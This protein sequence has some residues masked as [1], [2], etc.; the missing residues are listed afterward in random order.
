MNLIIIISICIFLSYLIKKNIKKLS[1]NNSLKS[2]TDSLVKFREFP[3]D[4][5]DLK[6]S[7]NKLSKT[8]SILILK[9]IIFSIPYFILFLIIN[10]I[11]IKSQIIFIIPL[12]PYFIVLLNDKL[13]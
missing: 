12:S 7:L 5:T 1:L 11:Q 9:L 2:Y 13:S 10:L 6:Y 4:L 3:K 8:G